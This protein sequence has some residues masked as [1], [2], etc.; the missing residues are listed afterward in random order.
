MT[1]FVQIISAD[2][3]KGQICHGYPNCVISNLLLPDPVRQ[4]PPKSRDLSETAMGEVRTHAQS[5]IELPTRELC[6]SSCGKAGME[7]CSSKRT[8]VVSESEKQTIES[9]EREPSDQMQSSEEAKGL[10]VRVSEAGDTA[11]N[12]EKSGEG[13]VS[14]VGAKF[15]NKDDVITQ[16]GGLGTKEEGR[17]DDQTSAGDVLKD[18]KEG[19]ATRTDTNSSIL[20]QGSSSLETDAKVRKLVV[21]YCSVIYVRVWLGRTGN[22]KYWFG[23]SS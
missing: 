5:S 19:D 9:G 20:L 14:L 1:L 2:E 15:S 8:A 18:V 3:F 23:M 6:C 13:G 10:H 17:C 21:Q 7:S 22:G 12:V 4:S 11:A 16:D